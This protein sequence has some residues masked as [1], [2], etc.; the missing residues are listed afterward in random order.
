MEGSKEKKRI[1]KEDMIG[2]GREKQRFEATVLIVAS[3]LIESIHH[4][5]STI[6]EK[7]VITQLATEVE[8]SKAAVVLTKRKND[9]S[10]RK[11]VGHA[12]VVLCVSCMLSQP[13]FIVCEVE[14]WT[15]SCWRDTGHHLVQDSGESAEPV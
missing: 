3:P 5:V 6:L 1:G 11:A 4:F 2:R 15:W 14:V 13:S 12:W 8:N 10:S 7:K 9:G